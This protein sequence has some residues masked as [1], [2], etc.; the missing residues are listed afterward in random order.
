[1]STQ[2]QLLALGVAAYFVGAI[3]FGVLISRMMGVDIMK[4]GSGNIGAT[5]VFRILGPRAGLTCFVLD[6]L[7]GFAPSFLAVQLSHDASIGFLI[8]FV[9]V[10]GHSL[11]PYIGFKGG[12]GIATAFGAVLGSVPT[13][14]LIAI[15][16]FLFF[17]I[18]TRY[19]SLSSMIAAVTVVVLS[20]VFK[21]PIQI[22]IAFILLA[23]L[24]F[25]RHKENIKRLRDGTERKLVFK[26]P[27][28][29]GSEAPNNSDQSP[30]S[31]P[32]Q[33]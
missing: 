19:V 6:C 23:T 26:K 30:D 13:I 2:A 8:G 32:S 10:V 16:I 9:A 20:F 22:Q 29:S 17:L 27:Q 14:A 28:D 24:V 4:V 7:K 21:S 33:T 31:D 12:K 3:P 5:N 1:M 11:S 15:S 18:L 25:V